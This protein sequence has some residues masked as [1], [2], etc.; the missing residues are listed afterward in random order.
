MTTMAPQQPQQ[1][2]LSTPALFRQRLTIVTVALVAAQVLYAVFAIS[3]LQGGFK[4]PKRA[5]PGGPLMLGIFLFGMIGVMLSLPIVK[6]LA[7]RQP[8]APEFVPLA[9]ALMTQ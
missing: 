9:R 8:A 5:E 3:L 6:S 7:K 4:A 2:G 1:A